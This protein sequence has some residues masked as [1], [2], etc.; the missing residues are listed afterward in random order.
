MIFHLK[1]LFN[2]ERREGDKGTKIIKERKEYGEG[3]IY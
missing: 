1:S 2:R 3:L